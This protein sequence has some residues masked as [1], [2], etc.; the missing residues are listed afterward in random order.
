MRKFLL[1]ATAIAALSVIP[2]TASAQQCPLGQECPPAAG[3]PAGG[4]PAPGLPPAAPP[5]GGEMQAPEGQAPAQPDTMQPETQQPPEGGGAQT[6][7]PA[8]GTAPDANAPAKAS[9]QG[10][11]PESGTEAKPSGDHVPITAFVEVDYA[12][13][14]SLFV[15]YKLVVYHDPGNFAK[16]VHSGLH[17]VDNEVFDEQVLFSWV[18]IGPLASYKKA[19]VFLPNC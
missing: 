3:A 13:G 12:I 7:S 5:A 17:S 4:P 18:A 2:V 14:S 10:Q 11:K 1:S 16:K 9:S 6:I 19:S 15:G 8:E